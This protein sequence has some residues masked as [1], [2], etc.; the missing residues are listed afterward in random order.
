MAKKQSKYDEMMALEKG[1]VVRVGMVDGIAWKIVR[2]PMNMCAY[3]GIG[4]THPV[5]WM[6]Y[7]DVNI[8]CHGGLTFK[9]MPGK[10]DGELEQALWPPEYTWFGWDYGHAGDRLFI[11]FDLFP[12]DGTF[13]D[14][15]MIYPEVLDVIAQFKELMGTSHE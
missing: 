3:V 9:S 6:S 2:Q 15:D 14:A 1:T 5:A 11:D 13:W 7:D 8:S 12:M 4:P 10:W